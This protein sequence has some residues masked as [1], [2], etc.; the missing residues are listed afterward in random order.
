M[1]RINEIKTPVR[2]GEIL[3]EVMRNIMARTNI[4]DRC[5]KKNKKR[6]T[7]S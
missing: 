4:I 6:L 3:P 1:G 5:L 2:L 7:I